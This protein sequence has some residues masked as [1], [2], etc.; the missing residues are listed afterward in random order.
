VTE[1]SPPRSPRSQRNPR[2]SV[3]KGGG[4]PRDRWEDSGRSC[5]SILLRSRETLRSLRTNGDAVGTGGEMFGI[6]G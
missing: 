3:A 1:A 2:H 6:I 4:V 5:G